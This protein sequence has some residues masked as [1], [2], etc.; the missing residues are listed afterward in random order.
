MSSDNIL[1]LHIGQDKTGSTA[2]QSFLS[3]NQPLLIEKGYDVVGGKVPHHGQ[4]KAAVI[5]ADKEKLD[6]VADYIRNS[7]HTRFVMSFEGF[8]AMNEEGIETLLN[9][10]RECR[11]IAILYIRRRSDKFR[12]GFAQNLKLENTIHLKDIGAV[13]ND[14]I[15][16]LKPHLKANMNYLDIVR[17]WQEKLSVAQDANVLKLRVYEKSSFAEGDLLAD[18]AR[19]IDLLG[20]GETFEAA[21]F[22]R[23]TVRVNPSLSPTAQYLCLF[24][25]VLELSESRARKLEELMAGCDQLGASQESLIPDGIAK[26][27]DRKFRRGDRKLAKEFF[28]RKELFMEP[29]KLKYKEP[30]AASFESLISKMV[31]KEGML[32]E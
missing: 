2:I 12:S 25:R 5:N 18:F 32:D 1:Y 30:D 21:S 20:P 9:T 3:E 15:G 22:K 10:L 24:A 13:I 29:P 8:Y 28:G 6:S 11:I 14:E 4:I 31:K 26:V 27:L 19:S 23:P 7:R 16:S 17:R